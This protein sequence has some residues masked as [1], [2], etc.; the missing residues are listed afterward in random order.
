MT[1][2]V[3]IEVM[4][5]GA[6]LADW[7]EVNVPEKVTIFVSGV[8]ESEMT[9]KT[10]PLSLKPK[11]KINLR[12]VLFGF[13][14][15][16]PFALHFFLWLRLCARARPHAFLLNLHTDTAGKSKW[17]CEVAYALMPVRMRCPAARL[18]TLRSKRTDPV[19]PWCLDYD[20]I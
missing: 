5:N 1:T 12:K 6:K 18:Q 13:C 19:G 11:T 10:S 2:R 3:K 8:R 14:P 17:K 7:T 9:H 16:V 15:F 20:Y 4:Y